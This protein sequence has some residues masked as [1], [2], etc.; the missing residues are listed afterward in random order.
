MRF[1]AAAFLASFAL[2]GVSHAQDNTPSLPNLPAL[3]Q[4]RLG[5]WDAVVFGDKNAP[6]VMTEYASL[7]CPHCGDFMRN[8]FPLLKVKYIDTGKVQL[9][10]DSYVLD[11]FDVTLNLVAR[12][13]D[14]K[15][16]AQMMKDILSRQNEWMAKGADVANIILSIAEDNGIDNDTF[17]LCLDNEPLV[18][19]LIERRTEIRNNGTFEGTPAVYINGEYVG[20][21]LWEKID[22]M[23]TKALAE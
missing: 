6:V 1:I 5:H 20:Q 3:K 16:A 2:Q 17:N 21:P 18:G 13:K 22:S 11:E 12:C 8:I 9:H 23:I 4:I 7:V 19:H 14:Q 15:T 10:L